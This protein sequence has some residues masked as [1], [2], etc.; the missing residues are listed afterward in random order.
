MSELNRIRTEVGWGNFDSI[1][2]FASIKPS[3]GEAKSPFLGNVHLGNVHLLPW[4]SYE[5]ELGMGGWRE[6][7]RESIGRRGCFVH[8]FFDS[9][10]FPAL[11]A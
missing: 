7:E 6:R 5:N 11:T 3:L 1:W 8:R 10:V 4:L 9:K 2:E